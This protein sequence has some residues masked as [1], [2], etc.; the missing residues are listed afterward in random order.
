MFNK[1]FE[2]IESLVKLTPEQEDKDKKYGQRQT[3][4]WF[5]SPYVGSTN[6]WEGAYYLI[7]VK[8][9]INREEEGLD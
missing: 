2:Q 4:V 1:M 6:S 5:H 8:K 9:K 3:I 7:P